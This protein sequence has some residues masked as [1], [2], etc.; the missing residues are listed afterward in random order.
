M[1][2]P[3]KPATASPA[4]I[5]RFKAEARERRYAAIPSAKPRRKVGRPLGTKN[6]NPREPL[7]GETLK[8]IT[9]RLR[10]STIIRTKSEARVRGIS[11]TDYVEWRLRY[12]AEYPL[13]SPTNWGVPTKKPG[14]A[15][16][17]YRA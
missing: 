14:T 1:N 4:D 10:E 6:P 9:W 5:R 13:V 16:T 17:Q 8:P 3:A 2:R 15:F 7:K 11:H 12:I